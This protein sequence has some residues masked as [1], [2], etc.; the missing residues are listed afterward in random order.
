M[1]TTTLARHLAY[2]ENA[3]ATAVGARRDMLTAKAAS[4]RAQLAG[5]CRVCGRRL[6]DDSSVAAGIGPECSRAKA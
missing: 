5:R 6:T 4:L 1:T 3:V 2:A